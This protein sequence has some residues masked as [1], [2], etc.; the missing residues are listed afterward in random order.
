M[1]IP[2]SAAVEPRQSAFIPTTQTAQTEPAAPK[3]RNSILVADNSRTKKPEAIP[4]DSLS[5][6]VFDKAYGKGAD[7]VDDNHR[8]PDVCYDEAQKAADASPYPRESYLD[9]YYQGMEHEKRVDPPPTKPK[10]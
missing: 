6:E 3:Y 8:N 1:A 10:K 5:K 7:C 4:D 9:A 2:K